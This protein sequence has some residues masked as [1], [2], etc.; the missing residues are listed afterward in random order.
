MYDYHVHS[1]FSADCSVDMRDI[2]DRAVSIG[3]KEI[4]FTDHI[5]YD[6]CSTE[7][8]FELDLVNYDNYINE[9]RREYGDKIKILKGVEIGIQPHI[10]D[11]CDDIVLQ[12]NFDFVISSIHTCERKDLYSR[13][14]FIEKTSRE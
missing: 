7:I 12:E 4:C 14:F 1:S 5:D 3:L 2:L 10:I 11:R 13:D 9:M 8:D 6:F